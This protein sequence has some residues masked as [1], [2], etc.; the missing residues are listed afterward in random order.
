MWKDWLS[1][2]KREQQGF[3]V[4]TLLLVVLLVIYSLIPIVFK[5]V[6]TPVADKALAAWV[7]SLNQ[8]ASEQVSPRF[9]T[10][11]YFDPNTSSIYELEALGVRGY[12]LI[13]WLKYREGYR[14]FNTANDLYR[15]YG[16]DSA[17][18]KKLLPYVRFQGNPA[19][20][21]RKEGQGRYKTKKLD[22]NQISRD[23]LYALGMPANLVDTILMWRNDYW[24][25][26]WY[27][28]DSI[29]A[30]EEKLAL[31]KE[32]FEL[33][34]KQT[35]ASNEEDGFLIELNRADTAELAVLYGIGPALSRR[36]VAY[37]SAL[38]GFFTTDQLQEVYG[39]SPTVIERNLA[40]IQVDTSL[41]KKINVNKSSLRQLKS[42]PYISFYLARSIIEHRKKNGD[43]KNI[44]ELSQLEGMNDSTLSKLQV[45]LKVQ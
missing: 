29:A 2:S 44:Q 38:G 7:D 25:V 39:V 18:V 32:A 11:F 5:E 33:I 6:Q 31:G 9:D 23:A 42:H 35:L 22:L 16:L 36:I 43:L 14:K 13:N 21:V 10:L 3:L 24:F 19:S 45:Y 41:I 40:H 27:K 37:R 1:L 34:R 4:L 30:L 28:E 26:H 12:A 17:H 20:D 15:V 8:V